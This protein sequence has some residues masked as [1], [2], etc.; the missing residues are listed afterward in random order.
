MDQREQRKIR[1]G[2]VVLRH[3]EECTRSV[4]ATCRDY[5]ISQP[6]FY[7][8]LNRFEEQGEEGLR[9]RSSAPLHSPNSDQGRARR[10]DPL[11]ASALPLRAALDLDVPHW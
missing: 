4:S 5:G 10:Q 2:L 7:K 8:W 9:D 11:P 1:H 3:T 6:R